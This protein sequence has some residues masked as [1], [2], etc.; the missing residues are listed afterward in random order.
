MNGPQPAPAVRNRLP[1]YILIAVCL[2]PAIGPYLLYQ[3]WRPQQFTNYGDLIEPRPLPAVA[4]PAVGAEGFSPSQLK[5]RWVFVTVDSGTCAEYCEQKLYL[6]RQMRLLQG[7]E[8]DRIERLW[9]VDDAVEPAPRLREAI[10]GTHVVRASGSD[11]LASFPAADAHLPRDHIFLVDPLGNVML[12]FP[13]DADPSGMKRDL[14]RLLR[15][16]RIG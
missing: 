14:R 9:L 11:L 2:T 16:S 5:G 12:R 3:Y 15:Y 13:R 10:D 4:L 6:M 8:M 7:K 1:L